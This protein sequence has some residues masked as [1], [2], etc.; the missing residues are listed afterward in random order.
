MSLMALQVQLWQVRLRSAGIFL[1]SYFSIYQPPAAARSTTFCFQHTC[2]QWWCMPRKLC[3]ASRH[4]LGASIAE[5]EV[6]V[7]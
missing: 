7:W 5:V 2:R 4:P 1:F 6:G 3:H